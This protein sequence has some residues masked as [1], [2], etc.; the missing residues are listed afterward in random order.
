MI[1]TNYGSSVREELDS[2]KN[3]RF[4][5]VMFFAQWVGL[6]FAEVGL[7]IF[8]AMKLGP[9]LTFSLFAAQTLI[10]LLIQLFRWQ[11]LKPLWIEHAKLAAIM[12]PMKPERVKN[13]PE[14]RHLSGIMD[15]F[16]EYWVVSFLF[17]VPGFL[18]H[19]WAVLFIIPGT[20]LFA[21]KLFFGDQSH[22]VM[23]VNEKKQAQLPQ[24]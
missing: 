3:K 8:G 1:A 12:K 13:S 16:M 21:R 9:I 19:L 6:S 22:R 14:L 2:M 17:I 7:I 5:N 24:L 10:G 15:V 4:A 23:P 20:R 11:Q 18:C